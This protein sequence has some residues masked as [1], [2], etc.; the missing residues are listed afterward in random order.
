MIPAKLGTEIYCNGRVTWRAVPYA[1]GV[2]WLW[3]AP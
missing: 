2:A 1:G 3:V